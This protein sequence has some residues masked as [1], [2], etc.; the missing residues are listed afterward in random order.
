MRGRCGIGDAATI[1]NAPLSPGRH[2]VL[3]LPSPNLS[4]RPRMRLKWYS[5]EEVFSFKTVGI[6]MRG[7]QVHG[8]GDEC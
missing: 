6:R 7:F 2:D 5:L 8:M 4:W 3:S 1:T